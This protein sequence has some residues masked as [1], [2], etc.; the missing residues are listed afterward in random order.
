MTVGDEV[1]R[2]LDH[3]S[4]TEWR[5]AMWHATQVLQ[6]TAS[7]R[8]PSLDESAAFKQTLRDELAVFGAMAAPDIDFFGSR[9]PLPV[10]SDRPDG[11]P[12]IADVMYGVYRYLHVD[13]MEMPAGCQVIPHAEGVPLI[14]IAAGRLWLRATAAIA[15]VAVGVF[16]P[17]NGGQ[18]IPDDYFLSWGQYDFQIQDSWGQRDKFLELVAETPILKYPL[19][20][21]E[22]W[23]T[24]APVV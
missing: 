6:L 9:F 15:L 16:A 7:K 13:E 23:N 8:Y 18:W 17:E 5:P 19:D 2:S 12:D 4:A 21:A 20:F 1:R 14:E 10:P 24:W 22:V 3:W 11:R